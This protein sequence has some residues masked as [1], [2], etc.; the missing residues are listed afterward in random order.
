MIV[1]T[2]TI[3]DR[4][5]FHSLK[6]LTLYAKAAIPRLIL[7]IGLLAIIMERKRQNNRNLEDSIEYDEEGTTLRIILGDWAAGLILSVLE[8]FSNSRYQGA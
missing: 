2:I 6:D 8:A 4:R 5:P 7:R 1:L 3:A